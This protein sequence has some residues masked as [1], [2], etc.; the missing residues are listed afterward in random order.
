MGQ[1]QYYMATT[2]HWYISRIRTTRWTG[3]SRSTGKPASRVATTGSSLAS[4][5]N[6]ISIRSWPDT[7]P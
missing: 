5:A 2:L 4:G 1:T 7:R 6:P 3:C